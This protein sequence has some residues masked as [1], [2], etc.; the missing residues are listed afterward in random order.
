MANLKT[1]RGVSAAFKKLIPKIEAAGHTD[2]RVWRHGVTTSLKEPAFPWDRDR[3]YV[4]FDNSAQLGGCCGV[5]VIAGLYRLYGSPVPG[6][7]SADNHTLFAAQ[8]HAAMKADRT[9]LAIATTIPRQ[10]GVPETLESV[11]FTP[12]TTTTNPK[13]RQNITLWTYHRA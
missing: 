13:T 11:G 1:Y 2:V 10:K 12:V 7:T 9:K 3:K 8:L 4:Q 5:T 6:T